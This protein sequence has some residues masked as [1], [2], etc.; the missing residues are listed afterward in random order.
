MQIKNSKNWVVLIA[1]LSILTLTSCEK[2]KDKNINSIENAYKENTTVS[3]NDSKKTNTDNHK[4]S[5]EITEDGY[6]LALNVNYNNNDTNLIEYQA[7]EFASALY[8]NI[9]N[10][11]DL[12]DQNLINQYKDLTFDNIY[13][14]SL[15]LIEDIYLDEKHFEEF[16]NS[17]DSSDMY[18]SSFMSFESDKNSDNYEGLYIEVRM[19]FE[20]SDKYLNPDYD[21]YNLFEINII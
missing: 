6:V 9:K 20:L 15:K 5:L 19:S 13:K 18:F 4:N 1:I 17:I 3:K 10:N 16:N 14:E 21:A 7:E 11:L 8:L 2:N 12:L